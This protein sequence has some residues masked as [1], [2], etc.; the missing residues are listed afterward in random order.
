MG[1]DRLTVTARSS[2]WLCTRGCVRPAWRRLAFCLPSGLRAHPVRFGPCVHVPPALTSSC[3]FPVRLS[4]AV[5]L[6]LVA[7][8]PCV[9]GASASAHRRVAELRPAAAAAVAAP[10]RGRQSPVALPPHPSTIGPAA[11]RRVPP[12]AAAVVAAPW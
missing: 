4:V 2:T 10:G 6:A 11:G 5:Q 3:V 12:A 1:Y 7:S 9:L 8:F